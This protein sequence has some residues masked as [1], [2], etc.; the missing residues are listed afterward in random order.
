MK[1]ALGYCLF[2]LL[3]PISLLAQHSSDNGT[4]KKLRA[5]QDTLERLGKK[6]I[7]SDEELERKNANY[8]FI[9][10]LTSALKTPG[11]FNFKFDSVKSFTV[12]RSPDNKFRIISWHVMNQDGSYRFYGTIQMNTDGPLL[13]YPLADYSPFFKNPQDTVTDNTKWYGAQYY[14]IIPMYDSNP[15]Y[16]LLG[17]KGNNV[18]STKKVI[19]VL[20]FKNNKPVFGMGVFDNSKGNKRII[21]EYTR[22]ASMLLK[23]LPDQHLIVF[24]H[25]APPDPHLK[26]QHETYGPDLSYDGYKLKDGRWKLVE[27]LDMRNNGNSATDAE[28][29]D[30]RLQAKKDLQQIPRRPKN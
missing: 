26:D 13:M 8:T 17:W 19:E 27:N 29:E 7:N 25:L 4:E 15:Y 11:S 1:R 18:K 5:Y 14:D 12:L 28:F 23:Y 21:F 24:D 10:T 16:I 2:L 3:A 6:I 30:P 9:K 22:Q 20:S